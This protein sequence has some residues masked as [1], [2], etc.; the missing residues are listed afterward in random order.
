MNNLNGVRNLKITIQVKFYKKE[1]KVYQH[2]I[3]TNIKDK[4]YY[5]DNR[6]S[7]YYKIKKRFK[8]L[9]LENYG[10]SLD[11]I[12]EQEDRVIFI[13]LGENEYPFSSYYNTI[14]D[15]IAPSASCDY[16]IYLN[17]EKCEK[18]NKILLKKKKNCMLFNQKENLFS[19]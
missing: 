19:T 4:K 8:E 6:F 1:N 11:E 3:F 18:M 10:F 12:N 13:L 9:S 14:N 16:C 15:F 7:I 5:E 17:G 2:F